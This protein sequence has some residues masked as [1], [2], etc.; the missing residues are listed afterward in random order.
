MLTA[1]H[2][3]QTA[4]HKTEQNC[5]TFRQKCQNFKTFKQKI[6][7]NWT[8]EQKKKDQTVYLPLAI[9]I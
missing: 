4:L 7:M 5:R 2:L 1:P 8:F 9:Q 6:N 3:R